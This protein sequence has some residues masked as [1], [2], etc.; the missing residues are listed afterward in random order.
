MMRKVRWLS[1]L[2]VA[3]VFIFAACSNDNK[4]PEETQSKNTDGKTNQQASDST[5]EEGNKNGDE[6]AYN[7]P[8]MEDLDP[9]N[10]MTEYIV[11]G[12]K[13]FHETDTV[14]D[15]YVG[16]QLSCSS[17]H[18]DAGLARSSSMVG[19]TTQFPQY[20]QIGRAHV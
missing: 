7:P 4:D 16:N 9:K 1:F 8:S 14:L 2:M 17:C 20:R 10:P 13:V 5:K 15:E 3:L 6:I 19:V 12:Q 11:Y 18:A